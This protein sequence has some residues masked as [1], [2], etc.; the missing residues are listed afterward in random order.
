MA[1]RRTCTGGRCPGRPGDDA[2]SLITRTQGYVQLPEPVRF[3]EA[4][5]RAASL[6]LRE[7]KTEALADMLRSPDQYVRMS[8][9]HTLGEIGPEAGSAVSALVRALKDKEGRVRGAAAEALG[10]IGQETRVAV[11]ALK[12][13]LGNDT[14][15][16]RQ[17]AAV[18]L[19]RLE[20]DSPAGVGFL[21]RRRNLL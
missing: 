12:E 19:C 16:V 17:D 8:A 13:V 21:V 5:E 9:A 14:L 6:A 15:D 10:C 1:Q 18:A 11:P 3:T 2:A 4:W 7:G 20:A